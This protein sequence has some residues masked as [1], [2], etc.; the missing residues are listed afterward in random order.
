MVTQILKWKAKTTH[1]H[2]HTDKFVDID[3]ISRHECEICKREYKDQRVATAVAQLCWPLCVLGRHH[4]SAWAVSIG[5]MKQIELKSTITFD[6]H[7]HIHLF[8][9]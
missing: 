7:L 5:E 3:S 1:T 2:T 9:P 8:L 4:R 6:W